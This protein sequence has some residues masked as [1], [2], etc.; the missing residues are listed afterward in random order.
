MFTAFAA[1]PFPVQIWHFDGGRLRDVTRAFPDQVEQDAKEL[2]RL[3]QRERRDE[4]VRGVLAA[5]QADQYLLGRE[6]AGWLEL[7]R[8]LK[9]GD[10]QGPNGFWPTGRRY[11]RGPAGLSREDRLRRLRTSARCARLHRSTYPFN[12]VP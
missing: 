1:S 5:W 6:D 7:E 2:W 3:Y 12:P 10:L 8:A 4:D 9:R 11:L